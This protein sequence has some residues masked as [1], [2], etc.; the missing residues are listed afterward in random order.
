[1]S[2]GSLRL[3]AREAPDATLPLRGYF[4]SVGVALLCLLF[5][6]DRV[7]PTRVGDRFAEPDSARPLIRIHSDMKV[8]E[9]VVI[10]TAGV[11]PA[12]VDE[13]IG[14][15]ALQPDRLETIYTVV[16]AGRAAA[17]KRPH[18]GFS[19]A[20]ALSSS[21]RTRAASPDFTTAGSR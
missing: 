4:L 10:E 7:L 2:R 18:A 11:L 5:A 9:R 1:M 14:L 19:E 12:R 15:A 8:P 17:R 21:A 3:R 16:G 20:S 6:A 13:Q